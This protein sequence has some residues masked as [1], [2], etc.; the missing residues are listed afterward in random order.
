M[1]GFKDLKGI[2][3]LRGIEDVQGI[4]KAVGSNGK[5]IVVVGTGFIGRCNLATWG[6]VM[7][8]MML[9]GQEWRSPSALQ[10]KEM[11]L[12]SSGWRNTRCKFPPP[13]KGSFTYLMDL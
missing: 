13:P 11:I 7:L 10:A 3:A 4:N 12:Q 8:I 5:K 6:K 2:F 9:D 1:P